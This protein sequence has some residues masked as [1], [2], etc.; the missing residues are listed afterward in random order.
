M[1]T[2]NASISEERPLEC[3]E[4]QSCVLSSEVPPSPKA[5]SKYMYSMN[6]KAVLNFSLI[7]T[8]IQT[9]KVVKKLR[10]LLI[11]SMFFLPCITYLDYKHCN[12]C[13]TEKQGT[14]FSERTSH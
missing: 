8:F 2:G 4:H 1:E 14:V 11:S 10:K 5:K 13:H 6:A 9:Y 12:P 3:A 7:L